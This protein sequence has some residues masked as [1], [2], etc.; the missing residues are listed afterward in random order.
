MMWCDIVCFR[1]NAADVAEYFPYPRVINFLFQFCENLFGI[2]VKVR[3]WGSIIL[4]F[5]VAYFFLNCWDSFCLIYLCHCLKVER[6]KVVSSSQWSPITELQSIIC[7]MGS[8]SVTC[9]V[10]QMNVPTLTPAR[11]TGT[12][13]TYP[14]EMEGWVDL[15]GWLCT[16]MVYLSVDSHSSR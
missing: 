9:H 10:I 11:Q 7:R 13:F 15:A 8:H 14:G 12:L 1:V 3:E 4:C 2:S 5:V 16:E 6:L